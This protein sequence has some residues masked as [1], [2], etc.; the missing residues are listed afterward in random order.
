M[1][2]EKKFLKWVGAPVPH[3][4]RDIVERLL[5]CTFGDRVLAYEAA[6]EI[7]RLRALSIPDGG[8]T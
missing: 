6:A 4:G 3:D 2:Y 8:K 7:E 1:S 5:S